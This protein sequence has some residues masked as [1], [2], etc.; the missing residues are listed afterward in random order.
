MRAA[1]YLLASAAVILLAS[2]AVFI[3]TRIAQV[4]GRG[5][6]ADGLPPRYKLEAGQEIAYE[7][8]SQFKYKDGELDDSATATYWVTRK[9]ED[10]S[11]HVIASNENDSTQIFR[12]GK[13]SPPQKEASMGSFDLFPDGHVAATTG[14]DFAWMPLNGMFI[15]LPADAAGAERGWEEAG[16]FGDKTTYHADPKND[17][18]SGRWIFDGTRESI[19]NVIY[20]M[21][22]TKVVHFDAKRGLITKID[23][24]DT[25]GYGFDGKGTGTTELK[26]VTTRDAQW[27]EQLD[28]EAEIYAKAKKALRAVNESLKKEGADPH[29]IIAATWKELADA[30][31][32]VKLPPVAS[33]VSLMIDGFDKSSTYLVNE[34]QEEDALLYMPA[35]DWKLT[36]LDGKEHSLSDYRG[37]VVVLDFWYRG[38]GWCIRAMPQIKEVVGHYSGQPVAVLGM[39]NDF[40]EKDARFVAEKMDLNYPT[41]KGRDMPGKYKVQAF[42]TLIFIDKKGNVRGRHSGWAPDLRDQVI[43]IIDGLL[44]E[45]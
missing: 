13:P 15:Q 45:K 43:K 37:Q 36:D 32:K 11:W 12:G 31:D 41:L 22:M 30:R 23:E 5:A 20:L 21:G 8:S 7:S 24:E 40:N 29:A 27:M 19:F 17:P 38:C 4:R 2:G 3:F 26:S 9:N 39:N 28:R 1:V 14:T 25:Q 35:P 34:Q 18:A 42:P 44:S 6:A 33:Q 10:G 16:Q